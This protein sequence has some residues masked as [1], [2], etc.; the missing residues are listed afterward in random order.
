MSIE[1]WVIGHHKKIK[2]ESLADNKGTITPY[3]P[4]AVRSSMCGDNQ[5]TK[6]R[7]KTIA[8]RT[9]SVRIDHTGRGQIALEKGKKVLVIRNGH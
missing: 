5:I 1:I 3:G 2:F 4:V 9:L 7:G 6:V 8:D